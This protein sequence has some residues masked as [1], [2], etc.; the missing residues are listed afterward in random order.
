MCFPPPLTAISTAPPVCI[1]QFLQVS[2]LPSCRKEEEKRKGKE[3]KKEEK[4]KEKKKK[5]VLV[6]VSNIYEI[7]FSS[8]FTLCSHVL[9]Y[10]QV[11]PACHVNLCARH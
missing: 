10:F 1:G 3:E 8:M 11:L 2:L 7:R 4:G 5:L 6:Y 9:F